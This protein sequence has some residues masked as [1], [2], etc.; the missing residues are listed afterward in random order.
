MGLYRTHQAASVF[1]CLILVSSELHADVIPGRWDKVDSQVTGTDIIIRLKAG[2]WIECVFNQ[3]DPDYLVVR[4]QKSVEHKIRKM[5]VA[6]VETPAHA[7]RSRSRGALIGAL[8]GAAPMAGFGVLLGRGFGGHASD[9]AVGAAI[10]GAIGAGIGAL[11]GGAIG[12][13]RIEIETLYVAAGGGTNL[14]K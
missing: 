3:A 11:V 8:A 12:I 13:A 5:D 10:F 14:P 2:D 1:L 9:M 4:D 7:T 6:R